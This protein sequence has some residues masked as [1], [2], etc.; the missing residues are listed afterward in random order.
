MTAERYIPTPRAGVAAQREDYGQ[1]RDY[2]KRDIFSADGKYLAST[3]WAQSSF[4]ARTEYVRDRPYL[5]ITDVYSRP[6]D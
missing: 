5:D 2:A 3:T 6:A 4:E 1:R